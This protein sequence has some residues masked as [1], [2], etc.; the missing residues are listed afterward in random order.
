[1]RVKKVNPEANIPK[2]KQG[3]AG[4]DLQTMEEL[5]LDPGEIYIIDTGLAF[6]IPEGHYS[7]IA[8]R[9]SLAKAGLKVMGGV[10]D[11]SYR[12]QVRIIF[13]NTNRLKKIK[14]YQYDRVAQMVFHKIWNNE[15]EEVDDL[16]ETWRGSQGFGSTGVNAVLPTAKTIT[17]F[18][19]ED[20]KADRDNYK[21]GEEL[22]ED[23]RNQI[24]TLLAKYKDNFARDFE[25]IRSRN[26]KY[27]HFIDT[28]DSKPI[29]SKPY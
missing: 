1:M 27:F 9:S 29:K 18:K 21:L 13:M 7:Q 3:D 6:A 15:L 20:P 12:G 17:N 11:P 25:D 4:Y 8:E 10:I 28:G 16:D 24:G 5:E 23:E 22:S 14:L 26:N 19:R 2:P